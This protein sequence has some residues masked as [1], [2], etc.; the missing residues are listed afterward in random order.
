MAS[1]L[2]GTIRLE[3]VSADMAGLLSKFNAAGIPLHTL[4]YIDLLT[5]SVKIAREDLAV[6]QKIASGCGA[7]AKIIDRQGLYWIIG[8]ILSRPALVAGIL[9]HVLFMLWLPTRVLFVSVEGN[10]TIPDQKIIEQANR[11]GIQFGASRRSVRSEKM[12]NS[13]LAAIPSLQW[14]GINTSGCTAVISVRERSESRQ[15]NVVGGV[16]SIVAAKDGVISSCTAL[17][18][19]LKCKVGQAV[20]QGDMLISGYQDLGLCIKGVS[21]A[22]EIYAQTKHEINVISPSEYQYKS[23]PIMSYRKYGLLLGKKRIFF[24]KGS[25]ISGIGCDK[26]YSEYYLSLPGGYRLP[27]ALF[28]STITVHGSTVSHDEQSAQVTARSAARSYLL[29]QMISGEVLRENIVWQQQGSACLLTGQ[30]I[31]SE[32]IGR[33]QHE[34]IHENYGKSN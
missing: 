34:E 7:T 27:I 22:G 19:E 12:K 26:I 18:G 6:L 30:Y 32:M 14:A 29:A 25:G 31:C 9:L 21:A 23:E 13:L 33:V 8:R 1:F 17:R 15:G 5:V 24:N 20:K 4:S 16:S 28:V 11:C 2:S 3:I 10:E